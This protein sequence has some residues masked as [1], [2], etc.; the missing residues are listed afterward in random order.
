ML[1]HPDCNSPQEAGSRDRGVIDLESP[2][3]EVLGAHH[4]VWWTAAMHARGY[5]RIP[6]RPR[7]R[8]VGAVGSPGQP[9]QPVLGG[10]GRPWPPV[11][12]GGL[13]GSLAFLWELGHLV[14]AGGEELHPHVPCG[15][16]NAVSACASAAREDTQALLCFKGSY[17]FT[18]I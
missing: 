6:R 8:A 9:G 1:C 3:L 10:W 4:R 14:R 18:T 7:A 15:E 11:G 16:Q 13:R 2:V 17:I 5:L 12:R